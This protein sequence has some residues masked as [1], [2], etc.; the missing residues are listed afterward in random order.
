[1]R[2]QDVIAKLNNLREIRPDMTWKQS[3]R[4]ILLTQVS[5][6]GVVQPTHWF[7]FFESRSM[8]RLFL[9]V[10]R[11]VSLAFIFLLALTG[12]SYASIRA[13][14]Q[15]T[16]SNPL[17]IAKIIN[18][19]AQL[20]LTFD[21]TKKAKLNLDF[22]ANRVEELQKVTAAEDIKKEEVD[23]LTTDFRSQIEEIKA[24]VAK[25][26]STK[27]EIESKASDEK[28]AKTVN[29]ATTGQSESAKVASAAAER[30]RVGIDYYDP[31]AEMI[32]TLEKQFD[33]QKYQQ[34]VVT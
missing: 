7:S 3:S 23:E 9:E 13:A 22:A 25:M 24:R 19:R 6:G 5:R 12:S 10:T 11:P 30:S 8:Q 28:S 16:P 33:E 4:A 29:V 27:I 18:E 34:S 15:A 1:M 17:Y 2:D 21:N 20:A 26:P 32:A 31:R 14:N